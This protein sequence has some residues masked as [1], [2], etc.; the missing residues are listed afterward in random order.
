MEIQC[1]LGKLTSICL[2][3]IYQWIVLLAI[4]H[5]KH[6]PLTFSTT[7]VISDLPT[8]PQSS[9]FLKQRNRGCLILHAESCSL[10]II[11]P[12]PLVSPLLSPAIPLVG[13]HDH[14]CK[15]C[16]RHQLCVDLYSGDCFILG[17][18]S[19]DINVHF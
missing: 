8:P 10:C 2:F 14:H 5:C 16:S 9:L 6:F 3:C 15:Q 17:S 19:I 18:C 13:Q 4:L 7:S 12:G 11:T 1:E